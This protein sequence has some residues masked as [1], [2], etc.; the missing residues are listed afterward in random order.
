MKIG[1]E[2]LEFSLLG[3]KSLRDHQAWRTTAIRSSGM[4]QTG[5][6]QDDVTRFTGHL[7]DSDGDVLNQ[8]DL[9]HEVPFA[10]DCLVERPQPPEPRLRA[11]KGLADIRG[12]ASARGVRAGHDTL[13]E[14]VGPRYRNSGAP[15]RKHPVQEGEDLDP[16]EP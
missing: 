7:D 9:V 5:M 1:T 6:H 15:S 14:P 3:G 13:D 11:R 10:I 12:S 8:R 16:R 2:V 4:E